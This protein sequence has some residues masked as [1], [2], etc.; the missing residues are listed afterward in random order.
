[1]YTMKTEQMLLTNSE[2]AQVIG[3]IYFHYLIQISSD[4]YIFKAGA[5]NSGQQMNVQLANAMYYFKKQIQRVCTN[6][7]GSLS[8][9][10]ISII[11]ESLQGIDNLTVAVLMPLIGNF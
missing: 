10:S 5:P 7:K 11:E 4:Y 3:N 8:D 2:A 9:G 6:M 1:M